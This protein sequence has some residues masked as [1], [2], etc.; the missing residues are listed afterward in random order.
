[1]IKKPGFAIGLT[2]LACILFA[3]CTDYQGNS[4][5]NTN[6]GPAGQPVVKEALVD[7]LWVDVLDLYGEEIEID[8]NAACVADSIFIADE[9]NPFMI[10]KNPSSE[11]TDYNSRPTIV[12]S[13][14]SMVRTMDGTDEDDETG[15]TACSGS[16]QAYMLVASEEAPIDIEVSK[17]ALSKHNIDRMAR[18]EATPYP[19][20]CR[21]VF[22]VE[23]HGGADAKCSPGFTIPDDEVDPV[24]VEP[25]TMDP[26]DGEIA[27]HVDEDD[28][29]GL[30]EGDD[31]DGDEVIEDEEAQSPDNSGAIAEALEDVS[32]RYDPKLFTLKIVVDDY[33]CSYAK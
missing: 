25:A 3:G 1:M 4:E 7:A 2:L 28:E 22:H 11:P 23:R 16:N 15:S 26:E 30:A 20:G 18:V 9:N 14:I 19:V 32:C 27:E 21:V 13:N 17:E 10:M 6:I 33:D 24:V 5:L 8:P 12:V 29:S 31:E